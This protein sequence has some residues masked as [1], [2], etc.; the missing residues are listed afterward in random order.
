[1]FGE[2]LLTAKR[3]ITI[4][5]PIRVAT[6]IT[7]RMTDIIPVFLVKGI[8]CDF[9]ERRSPEDEAF[10][11]VESDAFEEERVLETA[12]VLEVCIAAEGAVQ[13]LHAEGEGGGE[14]VD[15]TG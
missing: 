4:P 5:A 11:E 12:V 15:V 3:T 14:D 1:M 6:H 13:V 8:V 7:I 2:N 9:R 10:F